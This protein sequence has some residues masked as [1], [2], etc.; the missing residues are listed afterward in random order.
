MEAKDRVA[1][2]G[3]QLPEDCSFKEKLD[4]LAMRILK[5]PAAELN[6]NLVVTFL[7]KAKETGGLE[8]CLKHLQTMGGAALYMVLA[9]IS[10]FF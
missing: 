9:A 10:V 4:S 2:K 1:A 3:Q 5:R 6:Q 8:R 7:M